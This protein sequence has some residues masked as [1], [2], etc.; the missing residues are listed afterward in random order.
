MT[1]SGT[2][3][4]SIQSKPPS[5]GREG[6]SEPDFAVRGLEGGGAV[7]GP[8]RRDGE[9]ARD[10]GVG[11]PDLERPDLDPELGV[12]LDVDGD[13][14]V[15][16]LLPEVGG[17]DVPLERLL[18]VELRRDLGGVLGALVEG[19]ERG[20]AEALAVEERERLDGVVVEAD[21]LVGV[22]D[23]DV[24]GEVVGERGG[25]GE[26]EAREGGGVGGG[27]DHV[28]A[29]EQ[30]EDE[31]EDARGDEEGDEDAAEAAEEPARQA[32]AEIGRAHV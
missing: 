21:A 9:R 13:L 16:Q 4:Q 23:G 17:G 12:E 3:E 27:G 31:D 29:E 8:R 6:G 22:A 5:K 11:S 26:G 30:V 20:V 15:L 32:L 2:N 28:R 25:G 19:R 7:V 18:A 1:P 10:P 14:S 24:D